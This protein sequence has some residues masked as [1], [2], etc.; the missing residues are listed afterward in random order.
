MPSGAADARR[1]TDAA[2]AGRAR[3]GTAAAFAWRGAVWGGLIGLVAAVW[4]QVQPRVLAMAGT[5]FSGAPQGTDQWTYFAMVRAIMRSPTWITYSYPFDLWW[6]T[7][8]VLFQPVLA[9]LAA[10][11]RVAGLP[12]AFEAGRVLGAAASGAALALMA[13]RLAPGRGWRGWLAVAMGLGG[14]V[15]WVASTAQTVALAGWPSLPWT[16]QARMMGHLFMWTP[17]A[18]QN[19]F[20][21]LEALYHALVL[22]ALAALLMRRDAV[23][24]VLGGAAVFSNPFSGGALLACVVPWCAW[25]TLA[26]GPGAG[27]ARAARR[28]ALWL[29]L[30]TLAL[31]YYGWFLRQ[32]PALHDLSRIYTGALH[33]WL[34]PWQMAMMWTPFGAG[35]VWSVAARR[36]RRLV[37]GN[38]NWR[39]MGLLAVSQ[40]ALAQQALVLGQWAVQ[41]MHF[42]R[43]YMAV[44]MAALFWRAARAWARN[45]RVVPRWAVLAVALTLPDQAFFF[46]YLAED[47][48]RTGAVPVA[49]ER[50]VEDLRRLPGRLVVHGTWEYNSYLAAETDHQPFVNDEAMVI[51]FAAER[52]RRLRETVVRGGRLEELGIDALI[53][54]EDSPLTRL[55]LGHGWRVLA[56][57]NGWMAVY[58]R[59]GL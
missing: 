39:L 45:P 14:G 13:H 22:G 30:A 41:P 54:M 23:A 36:G 27:R 18:A 52:Q 28:L 8:P 16:M 48:M 26:A 46:V 3:T 2:G 4:L 19:V 43:G 31:G 29:G 12:L 58:V 35:L 25:N 50:I 20:Y 59:P 49:A 44:G 9:A 53:A 15:F 55:A 42:N 51:P 17:Y 11:A 7:P 32:W 10:L 21:P 57:G 24:L 5:V 47:G 33:E 37:W 1:T 6:P 34:T 56:P 40:V 38:T